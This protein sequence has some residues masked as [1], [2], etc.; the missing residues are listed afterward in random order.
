[1]QGTSSQEEHLYVE[2]KRQSRGQ[3]ELQASTEDSGKGA[4]E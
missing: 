1:M 4:K 3:G 2:Q